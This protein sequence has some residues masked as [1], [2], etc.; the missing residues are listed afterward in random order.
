MTPLTPLQLYAIMRKAG[1]PSTLFVSP[2]VS[3]AVC[4]VA[5]ALRESAGVP[6]A[7]NGNTKTGDRSYGLLQINM[8]DRFVSHF[9]VSKIPAVATDERALL[10]P[11]VNAEA[12]FLLYGGRVSNLNLA[13]YINHGDDYTTRYQSHL[14]AAQAAEAAFEK[15]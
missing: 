1:F 7:F 4:M 12:G 11:D 15:V 5:I 9:L 6:T 2:G 10:D 13:W 14:P 8:L 3:V